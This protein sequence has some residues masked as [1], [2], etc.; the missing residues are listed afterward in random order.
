[1]H[2]LRLQHF[3]PV[4][5]RAFWRSRVQLVTADTDYDSANE[6]ATIRVLDAFTSGGAQRAGGDHAKAINVAS[7]LDY[8]VGRNSMRA[9]FVMD[10]SAYHSDST[11][12]YLGTYTF[13]N[14]ASYQASQPINYSRR[15]GDPNISYGNVQAGFYFQ[16]DIRLRKNLTITPGVRYEVQ[17]HVHTF[18]NIGPRFGVTWAPTKSG[19]TTLR[20]SAGLFYDWLPTSTYDQVQRVDGFHQQEINII[21]PTYPDLTGVAAVVPPVNRYLLDSS[22]ATPRIAR[23]SAGVDQRFRRVNSVSVTY[24]YQRGSRLARG[25]NLNIPTNGVRPEQT[26][27]NIIDVVSDAAS[28]QHQLQFDAS[29][30]PGAL[31]PLPRNSP[32]INWKRTTVF[33]N[34]QLASVRNNTDGP[35]SVSPTGTLDTE[36]GP[37]IGGGGGGNFFNGIPGQISFGGGGNATDIRHRTNIA[38]NNQIV[39]NLLLGLNVNMSSAPPYTMLTGLDTNGDGIFNDRPAGVGRNTLRASGQMT[40]NANFGYVFQFGT[41]KNPLPPGIGV[42][43]QGAAAQVRTVDQGNARYR[44]QLFVQAQ[45]LTNERNYLGYSG[46]L[47]S[48]FFGQPTA[49]AGMRKVDVGIGLSF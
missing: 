23:V 43:G 44:L 38:F 21:N 12:N 10:G 45:N 42:F 40:V 16:D 18:D 31:I 27:A 37:S 6:T 14:L 48:P 8:V 9:G 11:A 1:V 33:A 15:I 20:T 49:V 39:R 26:F 28:I 2:T 47:T 29:I 34:Y 35:F 7:D 36:W 22:F 4:G 32:L 46:T 19:M 30:N 41:A 13:A 25:E 3:G 24:S 17:T 5:R